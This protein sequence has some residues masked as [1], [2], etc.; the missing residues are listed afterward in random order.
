MTLPKITI[1]L[2]NNALGQTA[3]TADGVCGL[4]SSGVS[5]AAKVQVDTPYLITSLAEAV[6]LG[7]L[8]TGGNAHAHRNI[9]DFYEVAGTGAQLYIMLS[10]ASMEL[11]VL[12]TNLQYAHALQNFAQGKIKVLALTAVI[13]GSPVIANG[14]WD[15]VHLA[16]QNAQV[17][18]VAMTALYRPLRVIIDGV[19]YTGTPANLTD[20][21]TAALNM[22]QILL[23]GEVSTG[24]ADVGRLLGL[25]A[26]LPVQRKASR[27]LNGPAVGMGAAF[28]TSGIAVD[29]HASSW[30]AIH[31]KGYVFH[32]T[33]VGK[34]G[35]YMS[36]DSMLTANTDDYNSMPRGRVIDKALVLIYGVLVEKLSDEVEINADG[37]ISLGI[38]KS[39]QSE[40][41]TT[42]NT[43]MKQNGEISNVQV[44]IN[45]AQNVISTGRVT[46]GVRIQPV[47]YS[48]FIDVELGYTITV[49]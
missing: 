30:E 22:A 48:D 10:T 21:K 27:V 33:H 6:T 35:F 29:A 1:I 3:Q 25:Y 45:A 46:V 18:A 20:Y 40:I 39:W 44:L 47:G 15:R 4:I 43:A 41:E 24:N 36:S 11:L 5:V 32:K 31:A 17:L 16:A 38:I 19:A 34:A 8:S 28:F 12:N 23:T 42:L 26:T 13:P 37:T 7:I 2:G 49:V 9:A 14:L